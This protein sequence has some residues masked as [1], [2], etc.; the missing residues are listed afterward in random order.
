[1]DNWYE[2]E[3]DD[4]GNYSYIR[5]VGFSRERKQE[6]VTIYKNGDYVINDDMYDVSLE[7]LHQALMCYRGRVKLEE[8]F[9]VKEINDLKRKAMF[10]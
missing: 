9:K 5:I 6:L 10:N 1:M 2:S 3:V 4:W 7:E 8:E